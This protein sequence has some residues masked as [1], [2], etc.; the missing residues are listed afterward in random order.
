MAVS[1]FARDAEEGCGAAGGGISPHQG[2]DGG[3]IAAATSFPSACCSR[4]PCHVC[5][6]G[7]PFDCYTL[8]EPTERLR[9]DSDVAAFGTWW[10]LSK[11]MFIISKRENWRRDLPFPANYLGLNCTNRTTVCMTVWPSF[12]TVAAA[13]F[14]GLWLFFIYG[15]LP[16][17]DDATFVTLTIALPI[18]IAMAAELAGYNMVLFHKNVCHFASEFFP[19]VQGLTHF[20]WHTER[21]AGT[22]LLFRQVYVL[23]LSN[24]LILANLVNS[25]PQRQALQTATAVVFFLSVPALYVLGNRDR[26][27]SEFY[28]SKVIIQIGD[29]FKSRGFEPLSETFVEPPMMPV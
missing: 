20:K 7:K 3:L 2:A 8:L 11:P 15:P 17:F 24:V 29:Y 18:V 12:I 28:G 4:G 10:R 13:L 22:H 6:A 9:Y 16:L 23:A 25:K 21:Q 14:L 1:Y 26:F 5:T 27:G 19:H